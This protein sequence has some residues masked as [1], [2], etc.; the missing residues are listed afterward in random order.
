MC[1]RGERHPPLQLRP[2]RLLPPTIQRLE[3]LNQASR[4]TIDRVRNVA[5]AAQ[6]RPVDPPGSLRRPPMILSSKPLR[7]A[8]GVVLDGL[9]ECDELQVHAVGEGDESV[10][11]QAVGVL[12]AR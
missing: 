7:R 12:P 6:V 9:C 1:E 11:G 10:G 2:V 3:V 4:A 8:L 5:I